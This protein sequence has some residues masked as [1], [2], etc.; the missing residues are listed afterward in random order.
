M[1]ND[2]GNGEKKCPECGTDF[3]SDAR[4]CVSCGASLID[5][6]PA[7][8]FDSKEG[9]ASQKRG[10]GIA[11]AK[12]RFEPWALEAGKKISRIPKVIKISVPVAFLV[13]LVIVV[14]LVVLASLFSPERCVRRYLEYLK[15]GDFPSAYKLVVKNE[16]KFGTYEYFEKWQKL[17]RD[18]L[19]ALRDFRVRPRR[20]ENRIFGRLIIEEDTGEPRYTAT[21]VFEEERHDINLTV[22]NAGGIWPV[23]KYKVRLSSDPVKILASPIGAR[24]YVDG[25]YAGRAKEEELFK[26]ALSLSNFPQDL[27][28]VVDYAK[29][30][31]KT[32]QWL[33][34]EAKYI[35]RTF[36]GIAENAERTLNKLGV[37]GVTWS[38][39]LNSVDR[40]A[41]SGKELW[42]EVASTA[43]GIYW[44]FGGGDNKSLRSGL[45]RKRPCLQINY[46]PEG[47]HVVR[48]EMPGMKTVVKEFL[49]PGRIEIKLK[50]SNER[51]SE[52]KKSLEEFFSKR[53]LALSQMNLENAVA[54]AEGE[55]LREITEEFLGLAGSSQR[56]GSAL[57]SRKYVDIKAL[58]ENVAT[59]TTVENWDYI[60]YDALDRAVSALSDVKEKWIYTLRKR[61]DRWVVV[62]KV[63][64]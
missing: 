32:F 44:I 62:E 50:P 63:K 20:S 7:G 38:E 48:V 12:E 60:Y 19:G 13:V 24:V 29:K 37:A 57:K 23:K 27:D 46:L 16:G 9:K 31:M 39:I 45:M 53:A 55:A 58:S 10:K 11:S 49:A 4:F 28:E 14:T 47:Y 54:V 59:V 61:G 26:E 17:Q 15:S 35:L 51:V 6:P 42:S 52:L 30:L 8:V 18:K 5:A 56:K 64:D 22:V 41:S 43:L 1:K 25:I 36:S 21:L 3:E 40:V 2:E 33:L 34:G